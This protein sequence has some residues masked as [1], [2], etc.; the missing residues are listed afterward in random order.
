MRCENYERDEGC[1]MEKDEEDREWYSPL[2][3]HLRCGASNYHLFV[4]LCLDVLSIGCDGR[5]A[6]VR[7]CRCR[8]E[9]CLLCAGMG[10]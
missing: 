7:C 8:W 10:V 2:R 9:F 3:C 4:V 5:I 1:A 6:S